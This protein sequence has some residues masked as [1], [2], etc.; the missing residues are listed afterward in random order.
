M[1]GISREVTPY[2][3]E[4]LID[5]RGKLAEILVAHMTGIDFYLDPSAIA[6][7][8]AA[9]VRALL[10]QALAALN[11]SSTPSSPARS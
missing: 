11:D 7:E 4:G 2:V 6:A 9:E 8:S 1:K 5:D 3:V 10:Q